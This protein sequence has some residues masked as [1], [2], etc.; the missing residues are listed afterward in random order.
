MV[1]RTFLLRLDSSFLF[2]VN[3][4]RARQFMGPIHRHSHVEDDDGRQEAAA[5]TE[6]GT[7]S[8]IVKSYTWTSIKLENMVII[9]ETINYSPHGAINHGKLFFIL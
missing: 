3:C 4:A 6:G 1:G 2:R 7:R 8:G 9:F 5:A